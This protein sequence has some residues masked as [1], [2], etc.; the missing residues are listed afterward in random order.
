VAGEAPGLAAPEAVAAWVAAHRPAVE[1]CDA[2]VAEI[3]AAPQ[4]DLAMMAVAGRQFR[5]LAESQ[6]VE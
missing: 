5:A 6:A 3:R 4:I 2:L 1:R